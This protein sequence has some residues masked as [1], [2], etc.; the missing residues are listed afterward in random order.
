MAKITIDVWDDPYGNAAVLQKLKPGEPFFVLR[1]QDT[2]A[3]ATVRFWANEAEKAGIPQAKV[4]N[5][6]KCGWAMQN[7][8]PKKMPD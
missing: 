1:G 7:Y 3:M 2:L 5:A 8:R 4:D 6:R